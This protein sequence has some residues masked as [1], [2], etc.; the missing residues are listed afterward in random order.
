M[1]ISMND[2]KT[3]AS[4]WISSLDIIKK[5]G[6]SR[7]TL[8]NYIRMKLLP[9]PVVKRPK[10]ISARARMLGYFPES[11]IDSIIQIKG[12]KK[13]GYSMDNIADMLNQSESITTSRE[14]V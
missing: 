11:V 4:R 3:P 10:E 7:A 5:T 6:I 14:T 13:K 9:R 8:N 2:K 1:A 12:L